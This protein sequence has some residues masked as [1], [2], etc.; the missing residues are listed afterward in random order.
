MSSFS[1]QEL[2][3]EQDAR[4]KAELARNESEKSAKILKRAEAMATMMKIE[5]EMLYQRSRAAL[6][7]SVVAQRSSERQ[8]SNAIASLNHTEELRMDAER[9]LSVWTCAVMLC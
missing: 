7:E 8:A 1:A 6:T 9:Y 5:A 4:Q 3:S 2:A